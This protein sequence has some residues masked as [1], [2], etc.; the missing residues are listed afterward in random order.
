M[1][2]EKRQFGKLRSGNLSL[3]SW[4]ALQ[5]SSSFFLYYIKQDSNEQASDI[6]CCR[7]SLQELRRSTNLSLSLGRNHKTNYCNMLSAGVTSW[8]I[9]AEIS[10]TWNQKEL[11]VTTAKNGVKNWF[12]TFKL[13]GKASKLGM[14]RTK[15]RQ[16]S[17]QNTSVVTLTKNG[18]VGQKTKIIETYIP[19]RRGL[20]CDM[21]ISS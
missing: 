3:H 13:L 17:F 8:R 14:E 19:K 18:P 1:C 7:V 12:N 4:T 20:H 21:S 2:R 5:S 6:C 11:P 15:T 9:P 16:E 10:G